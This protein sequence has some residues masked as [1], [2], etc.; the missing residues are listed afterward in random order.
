MAINEYKKICKLNNRLE[1]KIDVGNYHRNII[2][3]DKHQS[4]D[5]SST[6]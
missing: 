6:Y 1:V 5:T 2:K 4:N 3:F